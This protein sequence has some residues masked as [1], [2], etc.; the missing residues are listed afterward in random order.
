MCEYSLRTIW[1]AVVLMDY[2]M[3]N[4]VD[5]L[6]DDLV[7]IFVLKVVVACSSYRVLAP[8]DNNSLSA[9]TAHV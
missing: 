6:V 3:D 5:N 9:R 8:R 4:L 1:K 7:V 2:L